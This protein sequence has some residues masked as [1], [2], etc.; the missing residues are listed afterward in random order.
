MKFIGLLPF[1]TSPYCLTMDPPFFYFSFHAILIVEWIYFIFV[2]CLFI[3]TWRSLDL[4]TAVSHMFAR[5]IKV[6]RINI[7]LCSISKYYLCLNLCI[8]RFEIH[9]NKPLV[10]QTYRKTTILY[11][12][13]NKMYTRCKN[14]RINL[15][16]N[17]Y[18]LGTQLKIKQPND[19]NT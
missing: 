11:Y 16:L 9:I 8:R 4:A 15:L 2:L 6:A 17:I 14:T 7:C 5:P 19:E 1:Q 3:I 12:G 18:Y 13:I 10:R